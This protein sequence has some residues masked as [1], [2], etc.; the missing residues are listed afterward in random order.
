MKY[1]ILK[2]H[3]KGVLGDL[4]R[5]VD[6]GN[7]DAI[8]KETSLITDNLG[9]ALKFINY[10][11]SDKRMDLAQVAELLKQLKAEANL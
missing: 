5:Y 7:Y 8:I 1:N 11:T 2:Q 3:L 10:G 4:I 9:N 6:S